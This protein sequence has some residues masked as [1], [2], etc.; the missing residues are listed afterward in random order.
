MKH[1][2]NHCMIIAYSGDRFCNQCGAELVPDDLCSCGGELNEN[3]KFCP[4]CGK[5]VI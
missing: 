3:D 2:P 1:C 4:S 5:E